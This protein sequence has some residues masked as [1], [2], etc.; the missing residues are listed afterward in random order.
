MRAFV[1]VSSVVLGVT[2]LGSNAQAVPDNARRCYVLDSDA[3]ARDFEKDPNVSSIPLD[4]NKWGLK[5][6][7]ADEI[8]VL[9]GDEKADGKALSICGA[10]ASKFRDCSIGWRR[11]DP[12]NDPMTMM[13][14]P[15]AKKWYSESL[16]LGIDTERVARKALEV[17]KAQGL[18][19]TARGWDELVV[20]MLDFAK[21]SNPDGPIFFRPREADGNPINIYGNIGLRKTDRPKD[22]PYLGLIFGASTR[23]FGSDPT[24]GAFSACGRAPR[25]VTDPQA[26]V[27][28]IAQCSPGVASFF[29]SLAQATANLFGPYLET[30]PR[31]I[32]TGANMTAGWGLSSW[33]GNKSKLV[34][35]RTGRER[36]DL[37]D[38]ETKMN[39]MFGMVPPRVWNAFLNMRG[40]LLGG[41][42]WR[43][44]GN[45]TFEM[46]RPPPLYGVSASYGATSKNGAQILRFHPLDLYL[47]G[48][49]TSKQV[50]ETEPE[51]Q[52]FLRAQ[53]SNIHRPLGV[54]SFDNPNWM[55]PTMGTRTSGPAFR[56]GAGVPA[57]IPV[58]DI[59]AF[60]KGERDPAADKSAHHLRQ[61]WIALGRNQGSL[62]AEYKKLLSDNKSKIDKESAKAPDPA[63]KRAEMEADLRLGIV[64]GVAS[65]LT[66]LQRNRRRWNE[67]FYMLT[68]WRGRMVTTFEGDVDDEAYWEFGRSDDD[69]ATFETGGGLV[70]GYQ[71]LTPIPNSPGKL[72]ALGIQTP[73][74]GGFLRYKGF[75][76]YEQGGKPLELRI[77]GDQEG[78]KAPNNIVTIGMRLK[79]VEP[80]K[81]YALVSFDGN[82][83][84]IDDWRAIRKA[85]ADDAKLK[86][87]DVE[88]RRQIW[89]GL[90]P[91]SRLPN[92]EEAFLIPDGKWRRYS[93]NLSEVPA[94][95]GQVKGDMDAKPKVWKSIV[96]IPSNLPVGEKP[97]KPSDSPTDPHPDNFLEI[98]FI[99]VRYDS[100]PTDTDK[101]CAGKSK[102]DGWVDAEDNCP[103]LF[104]P[105][106]ED[107]NQDGV[108]DACDDFDGDNVANRCDNCPTL[109]NSR[110]RDQDK[111]GIGDIC[112]SEKAVGCIFQPDT[113]AGP[114]RPTSG[115]AATAA[116]LIGLVGLGISIARR[117]RRK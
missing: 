63:A 72:T 109:T 108:G 103:T 104:N 16:N 35:P 5:N 65:A 96:V 53:G 79:G 31:W 56:T 81:A 95:T 6:C 112:D 26:D 3:K 58:A 30:D 62:D 117:I 46:S 49:L 92:N 39:R 20:F 14:D 85:Q 37:V 77:S 102:P 114:V 89:Q 28:I 52:S 44:N 61:L 83:C 18:Q 15:T 57:A 80:K 73:G 7:W 11:D 115:G 99:R 75:P 84:S 55:S 64:K 70:A 43:D 4:L 76:N 93:A 27:T 60:N 78:R 22:L 51:I 32:A 113:V 34:D 29:D 59:V 21:D 1:I 71:G 91:C 74:E 2:L 33:H 25:R 41:N 45:E 23:Q 50:I 67:N 116:L 105:L 90:R 107:G 86:A 48:F 42:T 82:P 87:D 9:D 19:P 98:D 68:H 69:R 94:F 17:M 36:I 24:S 110:Q 66:A 47:M 12:A 8:F 40:S 97:D 111:D 38:P 88:G 10:D 100:K 106:Q 54:T 101:D 13:P